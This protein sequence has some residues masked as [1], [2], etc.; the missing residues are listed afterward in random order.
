MKR[1][2]YYQLAFIGLLDAYPRLWSTCATYLQ[3]ANALPVHG[4]QITKL[5]TQTQETA[6]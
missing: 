4:A 3:V 5:V 2:L 1:N 6:N